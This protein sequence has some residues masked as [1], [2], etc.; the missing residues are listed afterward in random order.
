MIP[1][2]NKEDG[3]YLVGIDIVGG[4]L[5]EVNTTGPTCVQEINFFSGEKLESPI[6]GF[7]ENLCIRVEDE[8]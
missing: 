3:L 2:K 5:T 8:E 4:Y 6:V 7:A 1:K